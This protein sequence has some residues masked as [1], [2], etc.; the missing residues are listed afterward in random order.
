[1]TPQ[2]F[3]E[4]Y[5]LTL[6][7]K[8]IPNRTDGIIWDAK[9][10]RHKNKYT[11]NIEERDPTYW[12]CKLLAPNKKAMPFEYSMGPAHYVDSRTSW[13]KSK[14][15]PPEILGILGS[16]QGDIVP[17]GTSFQAW[18]GDFGYDTDSRKAEDIF[19]KCLDNTAKLVTLLGVNGVEELQS[20]EW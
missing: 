12:E 16:L 18:C 5:K 6:T 19:K 9:P 13:Q 20:V 7:V 1:M 8:Q 10:Y 15:I 11:G 14:P 3:V 17:F 2:E 4:K